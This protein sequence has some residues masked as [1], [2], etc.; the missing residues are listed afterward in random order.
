MV[1]FKTYFNSETENFGSR[2][3]PRVEGSPFTNEET[4]A[5]GHMAA[6]LCSFCRT[7]CL[8]ATENFMVFQ[9]VQCDQVIYLC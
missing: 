8:Y 3:N 2:R 6:V 4:E 1:P 9:E 7:W 5:Y